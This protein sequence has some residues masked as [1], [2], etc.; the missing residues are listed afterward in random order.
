MYLKWAGFML[1]KLLMWPYS[2]I[3]WPIA[4]IFRRDIRAA[5]VCG[6]RWEYWL[7][8]PLWITLDDQE[9]YGEE[10]WLINNGLERNMLTAWRWSW[11]RNNSWNFNNMV[12][13][14]R[15]GEETVLWSSII[16]NQRKIDKSV[17]GPYEPQI[18][19]RFK[20]QILSPDPGDPDGYGITEGWDV[21]QG[22]RLSEKY[23]IL[24]RSFCT[25]R[26]TYGSKAWRYSYAMVRWG[27]MINIKAGFNDLG[28]ALMDI[29]IKRYQDF[30]DAHWDQRI[31]DIKWIEIRD[32]YKIV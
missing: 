22:D 29:K 8:W 15:P 27:W 10:W 11:A 9:D 1:A 19:R 20:W 26:I 4:W 3:I 18:H 7:A 17:Q 23:T 16:I 2:L 30:Y 32:G 21:N 13:R 31:R 25:Y 12:I 24:G 28:E 5:I 14:I 6:P